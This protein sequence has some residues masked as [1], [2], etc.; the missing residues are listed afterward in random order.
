MNEPAGNGQATH[1]LVDDSAET[2]A[3][4]QFL[5][6]TRRHKWRISLGVLAGIIL[7]GCYLAA[8]GLQYES[9]AQ[10]LVMKRRLETTPLSTAE[11]TAPQ[12]DFL[13]T[14]VV[15][16]TSP[17]I[18]RE[19]IAKGNLRSLAA[20]QHM[21]DDQLNHAIVASLSAAR[22]IPQPDTTPTSNIL[23]LSCR[24]G[25]PETC[26]AVLGAV[27]DSYNDFLRTS[28][29]G[30][31]Q[32]TLKLITQ[33]RDALEKDLMA[34]EAAYREI[35]KQAPLSSKGRE[36][37]TVLQQRIFDLDAKR[38]ALRVRQAEIEA[39]LAAVDE[40]LRKGRS[41]TDILD[42]VSGL[43]TQQ[44]VLTPSR[45]AS[46]D[47]A[48]GRNSRTSLEGE[49]LDLRLQEG[50]LLQDYGPNH[51]DVRS[52][53]SRIDDLRALITPSAS[54]GDGANRS[55]WDRDLVLMKVQLLKREF[56]ENKNTD[57]SLTELFENAKK[58]AAANVTYETQEEESRR[59]LEHSK[60]LYDGILS[61]LHEVRS[62][63]DY[64]TY[65]MQVLAPP[66]IGKWV[67]RYLLLP[68]AIALL[69]GVFAG[70]GWAYLAEISLGASS[71]SRRV[72]QPSDHPRGERHIPES[73]LS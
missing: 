40:A 63:R 42:M 17:R 10:L 21:S 25:V 27:I 29:R 9:K 31:N 45:L 43:S 66:E 5:R 73:V 28:S 69:T 33:A 67:P 41:Y 51:P 14:H 58:D 60:A 26:P 19:A 36:G 18:V 2:P 23:Y 3:L 16:V 46:P 11:A 37:N 32:E 47:A 68:V 20:F 70:L 12:E 64:D 49:L 30:P 35:R 38:S 22:D 15:V 24:T 71:G 56:N 57:K 1:H 55:A 8:R 62:V 7:A 13:T 65:T 50:K 44:E 72:N 6:F 52:I 59:A 48:P 34:K 61:R 54:R 39:A 53:R 4:L